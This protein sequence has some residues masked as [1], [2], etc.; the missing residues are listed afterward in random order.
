MKSDFSTVVLVMNVELHWTVVMVG[1]MVGSFIK[2]INEN[3]LENGS[4]YVE[5]CC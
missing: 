3:Y 5:E 4:I 1:L 2:I